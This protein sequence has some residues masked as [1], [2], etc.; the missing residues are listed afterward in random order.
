M[1]SSIYFE[2][3]KVKRLLEL[4]D[5]DFNA[6]LALCRDYEEFERV[7]GFD[8]DDLLFTCNYV[9]GRESG[10]FF[11]HK[12]KY[13]KFVKKY[14]DVI[15]KFFKEESVDTYYFRQI[16]VL[17]YLKTNYAYKQQMLEV[18]SRLVELRVPYFVL[19]SS[20][21]DGD[22]NIISSSKDYVDN[23]GY[24]TDGEITYNCQPYEGDV[25]PISISGA[26]YV[27]EYKQIKNVSKRRVDVFTSIKVQ[28]L[29]FD[30]DTLPKY[31]DLTNYNKIPFIDYDEVLLTKQKDGFLSKV[32]YIIDVRDMTMK[33]AKK[34]EGLT[35]KIEC[36]EDM[37]ELK[38]ILSKIEGLEELCD[39]IEV[40]GQTII[41]DNKEL[42]DEDEI[43]SSLHK[44]KQL[45]YE[46]IDIP[47][48]V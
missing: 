29:L 40:V 36:T 39:Y 2:P 34:I 22:Y 7:Y 9:L 5:K 26:K 41:D 30:V 33:L 20:E 21:V 31:E 32:E 14:V 11:E 24:F 42:M 25:Y 4:D 8:K 37:K 18:I 44:R 27:F 6:F 47:D 43:I 45:I 3:D 16:D 48:V 12:R 35:E 19:G 38:A 1:V 13:K 46:P 28:D 15:S 10:Y 23:V 17:E